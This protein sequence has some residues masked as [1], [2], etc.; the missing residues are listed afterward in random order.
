MF[1]TIKQ[2]DEHEISI[3]KKV[4][5]YIKAKH[6]VSVLMSIPNSFR[7]AYFASATSKYLPCNTNSVP[8][9]IHLFAQKLVLTGFAFQSFTYSKFRKTNSLLS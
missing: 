1:N 9:G 6:M 8:I 4:Y 7:S 3:F 2:N 5:R